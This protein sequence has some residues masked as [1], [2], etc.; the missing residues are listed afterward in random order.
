M[1]DK[2]RLDIFHTVRHV[3]DYWKRDSD[4][5]RAE[6]GIRNFNEL[7]LYILR[8]Q[9]DNAPLIEAIEILKGGGSIR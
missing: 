5:L 6:A 2:D 9:P 1:S 8:H 4:R 7:R 3:A